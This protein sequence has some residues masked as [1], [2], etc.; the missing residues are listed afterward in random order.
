MLCRLFLV[1]LCRSCQMFGKYEN[2][3]LQIKAASSDEQAF[4]VHARQGLF[5]Q[6]L[7]LRKLF[8]YHLVVWACRYLKTYTEVRGTPCNLHKEQI[9]RGLRCVTLQTL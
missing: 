2:L 5:M 3:S 6:H 8:L 7:P 4:A 9:M 1:L